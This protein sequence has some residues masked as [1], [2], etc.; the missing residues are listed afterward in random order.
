[1]PHQDP[2]RAELASV[3]YSGAEGLGIATILVVLLTSL[4]MG[5]ARRSFRKFRAVPSSRR[6][7]VLLPL[8][9]PQD[10]YNGDA[11]G[12]QEPS[13]VLPP[14]PHNSPQCSERRGLPQAP[15]SDSEG[16]PTSLPELEVVFGRMEEGFAPEPVGDA[17]SRASSTSRGWS[18]R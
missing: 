11:L 14:P 1:M 15:P 8:S 18:R 4:A 5:W 13:P 12:P 10:P 2:E 7:D 16:W 17:G 6:S 3:V 9:G